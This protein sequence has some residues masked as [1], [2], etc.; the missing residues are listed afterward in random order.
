MRF[1]IIGAAL[2]LAACT[3]EKGAA[4]ALDDAG[5]TPVRVGGYAF[6]ACGKDDQ[7]ATQFVAKN[8]QGKNVSGAV[9][10]GFLKGKTIRFD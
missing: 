1:A 5:L 3:D 2:L 9:C 6:F 7:F 10:A 4:R 8:V